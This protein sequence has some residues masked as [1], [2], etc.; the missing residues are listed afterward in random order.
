ML[1]RD[2]MTQKLE[3]ISPK[4]TLRDT[5]R[6]MRDLKI[7]SL[8]VVENGRLIGMITD[9]D[10]CCR[11]VADDFDPARAEVRQIMTHDVAFC[12]SYDTVNDA[13]RQMEQRHVQRLAVLNNDK[14][15]AG[16]LSVDDVAHFSR[17]MAGEVL[18]SRGQ[19]RH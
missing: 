9:R 10:I 2:I 15:I 5:A 16:F 11:G 1:V 12:F 18:D 19:V 7:G 4:A 3:S 8:P 13:V 17:Q 14:S 6:K